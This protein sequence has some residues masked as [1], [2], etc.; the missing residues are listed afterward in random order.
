MLKH[1]NIYS[2]SNICRTGYAGKNSLIIV[3]RILN[4]RSSEVREIRICRLLIKSI[5]CMSVVNTTQVS[6]TNKIGKNYIDK[7]FS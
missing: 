5:L 1:N 6:V 3:Y 7:L 4:I 2:N